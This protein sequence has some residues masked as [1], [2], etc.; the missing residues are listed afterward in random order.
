MLVY[1]LVAGVLFGLYFSLVG[2]GLNL[3]FGVMR[4]VNLAHGDFLMLGAFVAFGVVTL[5]GLDPLL[6]VPVAFVIFVLVGVALYKIL[7]PRL[8]GSLN[9]EML[10]I[11]LFFG[12]SQV[13][14]AITTIFFGTSERSIPSSA[15]GSIFTTARVKLFGGNADDTGGPIEFFG[16]SFPASWVIAAATSLVAIAF[17]YLYLYRTRLGTLTRAVM[18]RRDEALATGIDV[19]RI[20][21]AAFGIGLGLAAVAGVFAPFMF[22]SVTPAFGADATVTSF[23]VVVLGSLGNP[24]GTALGGVV[25][26]ICYMLVQTYLSSW[27]D[28]LP[29]VLLIFILLL[30]PSGLLGRQVRVA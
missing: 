1:A 6:A 18:S 10:S 4:I 3:V 17:V 5:A 20:S 9:P 23:A 15:L 14:Q 30:R 2:I 13:I 19:D 21:A 24:L 29:Y 25:Y 26:G 11:I 8:Q 7:V 22:G 27:A 16:Q 28:L 12:L